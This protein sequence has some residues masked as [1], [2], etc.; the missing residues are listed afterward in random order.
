M[1]KMDFMS[2]ILVFSLISLTLAASAKEIAITFDDAPRFAKG[3]FDGPTRAQK[4][5]ENLQKAKVPN[6]VFFSVP[7]NLNE[8]GKNRILFYTSAGYNIANHTDTHPNYNQISA[9]DY[10]NDFKTAD[11]ALS[12]FPNFVK[13]FRF[14]Y[15][16]EGNNISKRDLMRNTLSKMKYFNA[17]ITINNY[18]WYMEEQF[19][20]EIAKKTNLDFEKLKKYY[21]SLL[22]NAVEYYD[23]MAITHLGRSPKHVILLHETDL[24][25]LFIGD[26]ISELRNKGWDIITPHEAYKDQ[27]A[28]YVT[29]AVFNFNPGRIGEIAKDKGQTAGLWHESCDEVFLDNEFKKTVLK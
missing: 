14:P 15:L 5:I 28:E 6:T 13:W 3:Y 29:P 24:N 16:R 22:I 18:D 1:Y 4:L 20:S 2:R 17:Y 12:K 27:I 9:K 21:V 25:A 10:I 23:K 11:K 19:Q 7:S 8:E 26:L